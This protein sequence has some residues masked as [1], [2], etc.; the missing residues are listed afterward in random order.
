MAE[1]TELATRRQTVIDRKADI[2]VYINIVVVAG[3]RQS[4]NRGIV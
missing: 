1:H 4:T 2:L 3:L